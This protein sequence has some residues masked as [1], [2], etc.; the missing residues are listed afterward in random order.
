MGSIHRKLLLVIL[1][2]WI[3]G[4]GK[5]VSA[6]IRTGRYST[7]RLRNIAVHIGLLPVTDT[8]KDGHY[9]GTFRWEKYPL[10]VTVCDGEVNH[11]G[12]QLFTKSDRESIP[13]A[14]VYDFMERYLLEVY[15][16]RKIK[17]LDSN[18]Y[19]GAGVTI[20][21]GNIM[22]L[23]KVY[24]DTTLTFTTVLD[25]GRRYSVGWSRNGKDIFK[26]S[27]PASFKLMRGY[28]FD[29]GEQRLSKRISRADTTARPPL[30]VSVH[31]LE[32]CD[33]ILGTYHIRKGEYCVIP[34]INNDRYYFVNDSTIELLYGPSYPTESLANLLVTGEIDNRFTARLR[35]LRYG[36]RTE[37]FCVSLNAL[38]N[39]FLEEG[40]TPY[41]GLKGFYPEKNLITA[42]FEM[43]NTTNGYEHLMSV[44]F[45]T[46]TLKDKKGEIEI[47]LTPYIPLHDI[48]ALYK[49]P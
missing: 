13:A 20:E 32:K 21:H 39:Y 9:Y 46:N 37:E 28:T 19:K 47:R 25:S 26:I 36:G 40:C 49:T 17:S 43:V 31:E 12:I 38:I 8:I 11:I 1:V 29:E 7:D 24:G 35:M 45:N 23:H 42:L 33:S 3:L 5:A 4:I 44:T 15:L 2:I 27:F 14:Q 41:F 6:E 34:V 18:H 22:S 30:A 48:K 10:N 16:G